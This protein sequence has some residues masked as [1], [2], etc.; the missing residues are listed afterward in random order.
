MRLHLDTDV[1]GAFILRSFWRCD[2]GRAVLIYAFFVFSWA[3]F[4]AVYDAWKHMSRWNGAQLPAPPRSTARVPLVPPRS[5]VAQQ[6][7]VK[8]PAAKW[9]GLVKPSTWPLGIAWH[10]FSSR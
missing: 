5:K 3:T 9:S 10:G 7:S 6:R 1:V 4:F 2:F 8:K